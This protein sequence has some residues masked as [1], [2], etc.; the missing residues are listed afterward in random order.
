M[1]P[2]IEDGHHVVGLVRDVGVCVPST[3]TPNGLLPTPTVAMT[4]CVV[5]SMTETLSE[6]QFVTNTAPP[7]SSTATPKGLVPT[8]MV[9]T[10][11]AVAVSTTDT[12]LAYELVTYADVPA[13]AGAASAARAST[14]SERRNAR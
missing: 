12:V 8:S 9:F 13:W 10:T 6:P 1:A 3:A 2:G 7:T 14:R 11:F 5:V 4:V